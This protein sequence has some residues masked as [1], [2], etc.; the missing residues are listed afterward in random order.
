MSLT[1]II[2]LVITGIAGGHAA[3]TTFQ[4]KSMGVLRNSIAG[5]AGGFIGASAL[6]GTV[7]WGGTVG[8]IAGSGLG[9]AIF[10][11]VIGTML[12]RRKG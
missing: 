3:A 2:L 4:D 7:G 8:T 6:A 9:G 11:F 1:D 12:Q 10:V 5:V